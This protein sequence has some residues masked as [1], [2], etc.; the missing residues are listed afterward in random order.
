MLRKI[1]MPSRRGSS[2]RFYESQRFTL[3]ARMR[4]HCRPSNSGRLIG[5]FCQKRTFMAAAVNDCI[6]VESCRFRRTD[7]AAMFRTA[8]AIHSANGQWLTFCVPLS[9]R[10][11]SRFCIQACRRLRSG[12]MSLSSKPKASEASKPDPQLGNSEHTLPR[13]FGPHLIDVLKETRFVHK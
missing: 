12:Q 9:A 8:Q 6:W 11:R 1:R 2:D 10:T 3:M 5:G 7:R 4:A 13:E